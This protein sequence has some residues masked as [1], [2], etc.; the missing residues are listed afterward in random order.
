MAR[1]CSQLISDEKPGLFHFVSQCVR[2]ASLCGRIH[3]NE[4]RDFRAIGS[5]GVLMLK[6][7]NL[8]RQLG[9]WSSCVLRAPRRKRV[10][11]AV[12]RV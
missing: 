5:A 6:A 7:T 10:R 2:H 11:N 9:Q 1:S 3:E 4:C 8:D 12:M